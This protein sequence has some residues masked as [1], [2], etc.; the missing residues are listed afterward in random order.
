M[1][2]LANSFAP[3]MLKTLC[4]ITTLSTAVIALLPLAPKVALGEGCYMMTS[5]GRRIDL[6]SLCKGIQFPDYSISKAD[7][8]N[9][10]SNKW[11]QN[12]DLP[13]YCKQKFGS[14][15]AASLQENNALGWKC[16]IGGQALNISYDEACNM[17]YGPSARPAMA[18]FD[19]VGSWHCRVNS[20]VG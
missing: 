13:S 2:I 1:F 3:V 17:Q 10:H 4:L 6:S 12:L 19:D 16:M 8:S 15:A 11:G 20:N 9:N 7:K 5:N 14:E 18:D